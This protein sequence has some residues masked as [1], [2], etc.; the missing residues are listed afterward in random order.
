MPLRT[1][2]HRATAAA[3]A[4]VEPA[5]A[6]RDRASRFETRAQRGRPA[7]AVR[8]RRVTTR[9]LAAA[10]LALTLA[11][12]AC[13]DSKKPAAGPASS[14]GASVAVASS[15]AAPECARPHAAGQTTETLDFEGQSR[16]YELYVPREYD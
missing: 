11:L 4:R 16:T 6:R 5:L 9:R 8:L 15:S 10:L 2:R 12:A 14:S 13:S 7:Q 3:D 1:P